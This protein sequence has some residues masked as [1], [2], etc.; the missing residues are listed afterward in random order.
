MENQKKIYIAGYDV[1]HPQAKKIGE[2][3]KKL[4]NL[5]GYKGMFPL[6]NEIQGNNKQDVASKIFHKNIE[7]IDN[8]DIIVA[9]L[10]SFRGVEPDSGTCFECGYGYAKGKKIYGYVSN[11]ITILDKVK[12]HDKC[13]Y[14]NGQLFDANGYGIENFDLPLNLMLSIPIIIVEGG[15]EQCLKRILENNNISDKK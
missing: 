3:Y 11:K 6:D 1:F 9:N 5:Y 12:K 14:T 2:M 10:N 4:C 15:F 8:C 13:T 7:C